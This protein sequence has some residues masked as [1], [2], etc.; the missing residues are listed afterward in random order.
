MAEP[1]GG[2]VFVAVEL[3]GANGA[4]EINAINFLVNDFLVSCSCFEKKKKISL[5]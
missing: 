3:E 4:A 1:N 2:V 5:R